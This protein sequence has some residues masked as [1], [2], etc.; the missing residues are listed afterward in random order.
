MSKEDN[1]RDG[2][3]NA[4]RIKMDENAHVQGKDNDKNGRRRVQCGGSRKGG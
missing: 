4:R 3:K 2:K 1:C